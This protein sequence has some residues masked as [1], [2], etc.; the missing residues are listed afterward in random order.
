[1]TILSVMIGR[2]SENYLMYT[3]EKQDHDKNRYPI[4]EH[5]QK[6]K[7]RIVNECWRKIQKL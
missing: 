5:E 3:G 2:C 7:T 6:Y 4:K 1:M